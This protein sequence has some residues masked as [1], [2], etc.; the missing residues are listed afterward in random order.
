VCLALSWIIAYFCLIRGIQTAGKVVYFVTVFPYII[1][2]AI[3]IRVLTLDGA[4]EGIEFYIT[5][6]WE[7]LLSIGV[8]GDAASQIFYSFGLACGSLV[9]FA[10][11]NKV[12]C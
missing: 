10:S 6:N 9:T 2:T 1:L 4:R 3:L 8:W 11:Y 12:S 7:N 5:P